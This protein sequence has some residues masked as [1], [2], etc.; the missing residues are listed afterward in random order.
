MITVVDIIPD[1]RSERP[2]GSATNLAANETHQIVHI[3]EIV[4]KIGSYEYQII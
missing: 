3:L 2:S 1:L 4:H